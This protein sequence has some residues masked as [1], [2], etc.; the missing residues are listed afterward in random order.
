MKVIPLLKIEVQEVN[1]LHISYNCQN[2][3]KTCNDHLA[4][5]SHFQIRKRVRKIKR[6]V[7]R[8]KERNIH[9]SILLS[10]LSTLYNTASFCYTCPIWFSQVSQ[11]GVYPPRDMKY[12][13]NFY[14]TLVFFIFLSF[15]ATKFCCILKEK[16]ILIMGMEATA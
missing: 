3:Q 8:K 11:E 14:R 16:I 9:F 13:S 5:F 4:Q 6:N 2:F 10:T 7:F 15:S 12:A 1:S